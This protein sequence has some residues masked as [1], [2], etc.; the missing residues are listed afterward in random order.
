[1]FKI[2]SDHSPFDKNVS[3]LGSKPFCNILLHSKALNYFLQWSI[4]PTPAAKRLPTLPPCFTGLETHVL[5]LYYSAV[6][7][8]P[9]LEDHQPLHILYVSLYLK[10]PFL[11]LLSLLMSSLNQ[12]WYMR[13]TYNMCREVW[14]PLLHVLIVIHHHTHT[15]STVPFILSLMAFWDSNGFLSSAL[16]YDYIDCL[17]FFCPRVYSTSHISVVIRTINN[18]FISYVLCR[19]SHRFPNVVYFLIQYYHI[20]KF[21]LKLYA[22]TISVMH[23]TWAWWY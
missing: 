22:S 19:V 9:V 21:N 17:F 5:L 14:E 8:K 7:L 20:L 3:F 13:K 15:T 12:V 1:L 10:H 16:N 11:V 4:P 2:T 23:L 6:F 18:V